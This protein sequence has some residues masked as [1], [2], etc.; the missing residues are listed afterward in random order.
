VNPPTQRH[1]IA[2]TGLYDLLKPVCPATHRL[3]VGWGWEVPGPRVFEP[4]LM[5]VARDAPDED[6]LRLPPPMLIV[7]V[8]SPSTRDVDR[9]PK[10]AYYGAGGLSW[11]WIVELDDPVVTVFE[12]R[13]GALVERQRIVSPE[14]AVGPFPVVL[15]PAALVS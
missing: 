4:D 8:S 14:L 11:Y 15:D 5:I 13:D 7:E 2:V 1:D 9:G 6:I 3:S 12:G 10:L